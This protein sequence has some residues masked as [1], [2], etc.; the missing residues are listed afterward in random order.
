MFR[1]PLNVI[2]PEAHIGPLHGPWPEGMCA[3][4]NREA[5]EL[6]AAHPYVYGGPCG[7]CGNDECHFIDDTPEHNMSFEDHLVEVL[8]K[9]WGLSWEYKG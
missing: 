3:R 5:L 2:H 9:T 4:I 6:V 8:V 7:G 1:P